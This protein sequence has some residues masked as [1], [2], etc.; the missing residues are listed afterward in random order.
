[1]DSVAELLAK[2][3][4]AAGI[5]RITPHKLRSTAACMLAKNDIPVKAIASQLGHNNITTTMRYIDVFNED[6]EKTKN[7]LDNL[8]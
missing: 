1:M 8:V 4:D 5:Q 2:Y 6:M 7:I 3:G